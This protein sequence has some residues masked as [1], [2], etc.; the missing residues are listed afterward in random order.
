MV[1]PCGGAGVTT[2]IATIGI[3]LAKTVLHAVAM[4][5]AGRWCSGAGWT[6]A[7]WWS[8]WPIRGRA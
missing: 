1:R 3:D 5:A 7:S 2:M 6:G 4:D 8:G